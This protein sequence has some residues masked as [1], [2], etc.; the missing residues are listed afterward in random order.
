MNS[1]TFR[2]RIRSI[3][4]DNQFDR[5]VKNKKSGKL[6]FKS[7]YKAG[8]SQKVFKKK[9]ER[10]GKVY[11]ISLMLDMSGS[12]NG[13]KIKCAINAL[14][15]V[16]GALQKEEFINLEICG[17]NIACDLLVKAFTDRSFTPESLR[18]VLE[19][20]WHH[21]RMG[22][23]EW[24]NCD[25]VNR[26][27]NSSVHSYSQFKAEGYEQAQRT[28]HGDN[29][30]P[31]AIKLCHKRILENKV[32]NNIIIVLSDGRPTTNWWRTHH[33]P[34]RT[35]DSFD[36]KHEVALAMKS[37]IEVYAIGILTEDVY[38]YYPRKNTE[39]IQNPTEIFSKVVKLIKRNI[40]RK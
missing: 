32:G 31:I 23:E 39:V 33:F 2:E 17:Y 16:Y 27:F 34:D 36:L 28:L 6:H 8:F 9:E 10:K 24:R 22:M 3:L 1:F 11:N 13:D 35:I 26:I 14:V 4:R 5:E 19:A 21:S 18:T 20:V 12:M 29:Y 30:D 25:D 40:H 7:L 38:D 15:E 37:G